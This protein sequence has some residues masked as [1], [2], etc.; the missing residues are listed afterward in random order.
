MRMRI[1]FGIIAAAACLSIS[2]V[3]ASRE[4]ESRDLARKPSF[5]NRVASIRPGSYRSPGALRKVVVQDDD[6][7]A[8]AKASGAVEI[9]DYGSF[10]LLMMDEAALQQSEQRFQE[11]IGRA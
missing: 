8:Q 9:A 3:N 7:F 4:S 6:A 5:A 1:I 2:A 10:R 11:E